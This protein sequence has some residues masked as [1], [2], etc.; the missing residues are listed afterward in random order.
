[1]YNDRTLRQEQKEKPVQFVKAQ[2]TSPIPQEKEHVTKDYYAHRKDRLQT[3]F[4]YKNIVFATISNIFICFIFLLLFLFNRTGIP[5][6]IP[7]KETTRD[8]KTS[9]NTFLNTKLLFSQRF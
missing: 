2:Q 1:M 5:R 4:T 7:S 9:V 6:A 8:S 3:K